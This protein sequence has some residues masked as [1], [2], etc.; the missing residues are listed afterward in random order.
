MADRSGG[1]RS[2]GDSSTSPT[3]QQGVYAI[4]VAAELTGWEPHTLRSWERAGLLNPHR[5]SGGT[6][7]YSPDDL[8]LVRHIGDMVNAGL[9]LPGI[10]RVLE[11]EQQLEQA[12]QEIDRLNRLLESSD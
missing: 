4:S 9:N 3:G 12:M 11:L 1:A 7:R 2:R 8:E 6:R 5:S 10:A